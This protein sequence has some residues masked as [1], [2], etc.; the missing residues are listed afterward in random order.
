MNATI[1]QNFY[2][3][4]KKH[5]PFVAYDLNPAPAATDLNTIPE[6]LTLFCEVTGFKPQQIADN[7]DNA[8]ILFIVVAG[9]LY[10]PLLYRFNERYPY[11]VSLGI[12]KVLELDKGRVMYFDRIARKYLKV[13]KSFEKK[14]D[15]IYKRISES[16]IRSLESI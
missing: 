4:V 13:Y 11:G 6:I 8:L 12:A 2:H 16:L 7:Y 14:A 9:R 3:R 15:D 5:Y 1:Y 10:N